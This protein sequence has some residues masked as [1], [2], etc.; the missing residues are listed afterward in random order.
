MSRHY[1]A[2]PTHRVGAHSGATRSASNASVAP[3]QVS[4]S[5]A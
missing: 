5:R 1:P 2:H 4:R 3:T